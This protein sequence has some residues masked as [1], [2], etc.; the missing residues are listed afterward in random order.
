MQQIITQAGWT[1][2]DLHFWHYHD[3]DHVVVDLVI[4]RGRQTWSVQ[5]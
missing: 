3:T 2:P 4:T 5:R 1:D